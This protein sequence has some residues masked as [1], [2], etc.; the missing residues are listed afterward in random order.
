[1]LKDNDPSTLQPW[2]KINY[3]YQDMCAKLL[4]CPRYLF[5]Y[6]YDCW[7]RDG[8][9]VNDVIRCLKWLRLPH[10]EDH[11]AARDCATKENRVNGDILSAHSK[12]FA[13]AWNDSVFCRNCAL[14]VASSGLVYRSGQKFSAT[15]QM[16]T[17]IKILMTCIWNP[18]DPAVGKQKL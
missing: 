13:G 11:P 14:L 9:L 6:S 10:H 16:A 12:K 17:F 15:F 5:N 18:V 7:K 2:P 3:V 4:F 8:S 1:M